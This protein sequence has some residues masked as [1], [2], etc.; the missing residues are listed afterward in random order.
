MIGKPHPDRFDSDPPPDGDDLWFLPGPDDADPLGSPLPVA[1]RRAL[2][3]PGDW[4]AAEA[5]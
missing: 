5:A 1:D 2:M 4:R 3:Q